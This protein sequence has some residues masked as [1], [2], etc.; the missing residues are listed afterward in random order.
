MRLTRNPRPRLVASEGEGT[1]LPPRQTPAI[2]NTIAAK[3]KR[4]RNIT[5]RLD[6]GMAPKDSCPSVE[7]VS[8]DLANYGLERRAP[9]LAIAAVAVTAIAGKTLGCALGHPT[10]CIERSIDRAEAPLDLGFFAH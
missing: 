6:A 3:A 1:G 7:T 10:D 2:A 8:R 5:A 4:E 9:C